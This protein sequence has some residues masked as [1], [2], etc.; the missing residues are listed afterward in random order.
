MSS[1]E[2]F[3]SFNDDS[4]SLWILVFRSVFPPRVV[5]VSLED[6]FVY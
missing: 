3:L 5:P 4:E 6:G 1:E 2:D